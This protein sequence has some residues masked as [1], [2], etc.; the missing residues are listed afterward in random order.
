[1]I[2]F[3]TE[4]YISVRL[5]QDKIEIYNK[6]MSIKENIEK[7]EGPQEENDEDDKSWKTYLTLPKIFRA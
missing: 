4:V 7:L 3:V 1:M 5:L 6:N 2:P